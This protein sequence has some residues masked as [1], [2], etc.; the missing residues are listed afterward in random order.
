[1]T[2]NNQPVEDYQAGDDISLKVTVEDKSGNIVDL[3]N[4]TAKWV[5][6]EQPGGEVYV[7]KDTNGDI[8]I[9]DSVNGKMKIDINSSDTES[10]SGQ[11]YHECEIVDDVGEVSTIF[12]GRFTIKKDTA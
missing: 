8:T 2:H 3:S 4:Y 10:L 5:L 7:T 12:T 6:A 1:M 11:K 9:T